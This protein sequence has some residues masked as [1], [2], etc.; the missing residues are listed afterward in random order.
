MSARDRGNLGH[1]LFA[2]AF[3]ASFAACSG[4]LIIAGA[5]AAS[6]EP[7]EGLRSQ[8]AEPW[9][10]FAPADPRLVANLSIILG[11]GL[12]LLLLAS[13]FIALRRR[14]AGLLRW[15]RAELTALRADLDRAEAVLEAQDQL[16]IVY[17]AAG[18][19][20][21]GKLSGVDELPRDDAAIV[22][23]RSWLA[24]G[25][26]Q[27]LDE[28][29]AG[30]VERGD[31][32]DA[33]VHTS[34]GQRLEAQGRTAA[35]EAVLMLRNVSGDRLEQMRLH[36][37]AAEL[38]RELS[39]L[40]ALLD[41]TA[42]PMWLR[43]AD[44]R[45]TWVNPAYARAV[46]AADPQTAIAQK[47]ELLEERSR[48]KIA[49]ALTEHNSFSDTVSTM[50]GGQRLTYAVNAVRVDSQSAAMARDISEI[51]AVRDELSR[52]VEAHVRTLDRIAT[53]VAIFGP[54]RRLRFC[55]AAY[56][57]L[58]RLDERWLEAGPADGDILDALRVSGRLPEQ[59]DYRAWKA[60]QLAGYNS[61]E[62][63]EQ[64]WHLPD[65]QTLRVVA[66][67]HPQGGVTYLYDNVTET[68]R[69]QSRHN[70]LMNVQRETLDNL[71]EGVA[72]FSSDGRLRLFNSAFA[73]LWR[74][75]PS[76]LDAEPHIDM[77]IAWSRVLMDEPEAWNKLKARVTSLDEGRRGDSFRF[78]RPDGTVI[79][80]L[81]VPLPGGDTLVT[82]M[83]V[84]DAALAERAL[85]ERNE[86]LEA[87]DRIKTTFIRHVSYVLRAPLTTITGY[88]DLLARDE[89][90]PLTDKQREFIEHVLTS[91]HALLA[92]IND[93]LDLATIDAGTMELEFAPVD[94]N[95]VMATAAHGLADR[96]EQANVELELEECGD[97]GTFI[98]D[99][100][101][102]TQVLFNLLANAVAY[103]RAGSRV[104]VGCARAGDDVL[105]SVADEGPG[106]APELQKMIFE[107]FESHGEGAGQRGAGLGLSIVKS[108]VE[109]HGGEVRLDSRPGQGTT[110]TCV[111]PISPDVA[112]SRPRRPPAA[113]DALP[114]EADR[115]AR[116]D[117]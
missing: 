100:K 73:K 77:V 72:L 66:E 22:A 41:A 98:A 87:A 59:A 75:A 54:D 38:D 39:G 63:T 15:Q 44:G 10:G 47:R 113:K 99:A 60:R 13:G 43:D 102:V 117:G 55:N 1:R 31:G 29:L 48:A 46:G 4:L 115:A 32:F 25:S 85:R 67:P 3:A 91:S 93:I 103:T 53:A 18:P 2:A 69:L 20:V 107:R 61:L 81:T 11:L 94:L 58:W 68:L 82:F 96:L 14:L 89:T 24:N 110:V 35:G 17:G 101:R 57:A 71:N 42:V 34:G 49:A 21:H 111:F 84:T 106:I 65:G 78:E 105:L 5:A 26:A 88:A 56:R 64:W 27:A 95:E 28:L 80:C 45:I 109:L 50:V 51:E 112:K 114:G 19:V 7:A 62:P 9:F 6:P 8:L 12:A 16:S 92:I 108:L 52:H 97:I 37:A 83:D 90:G 86:A 23:F 104:R 30:L 74:L 70:A 40:R 33:I 116:A 79:D 36:E 76:Q